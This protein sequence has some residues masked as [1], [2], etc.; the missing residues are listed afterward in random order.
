VKNEKIVS[1]I[2]KGESAHLA[3]SKS[4]MVIR[5]EEETTTTTTTTRVPV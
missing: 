1:N 4:I 5:H 2:N 3:I